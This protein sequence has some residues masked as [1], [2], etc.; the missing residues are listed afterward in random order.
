MRGV[1]CP[2]FAEDADPAAQALVQELVVE[3]NR[4]IGDLWC[5]RARVCVRALFALSLCHSFPRTQLTSPRVK[6]GLRR[7]GEHTAGG[8]AHRAHSV[9]AGR[10]AGQ[11]PRH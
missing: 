3:Y 10:R 2:Q 11:R 7:A 5:A 9:R 6:Q 1:P 4:F 8:A